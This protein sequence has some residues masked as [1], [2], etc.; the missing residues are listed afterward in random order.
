MDSDLP[1]NWSACEVSYSV[2]FLISD[3]VFSFMFGFFLAGYKEVFVKDDCYRL[4]TFFEKGTIETVLPKGYI[5]TFL[6]RHPAKTITSWYNGTAKGQGGSSSCILNKKL[7]FSV[8][9]FTMMFTWRQMH[10]NTE[11]CKRSWNR[12][13]QSFHLI[14]SG[15]KGFGNE[16]DYELSVK[17]LDYV[18]KVLGQKAIVVEA[19]DLQSDPGKSA[20]NKETQ[21]HTHTHTSR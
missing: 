19:D 15:L 7:P 16:M 11:F 8:R 4:R 18:T 21:T 9:N 13:F 20:W 12:L 5:H 2:L 17:M 3:Q 14:R 6:I 10:S 1:D